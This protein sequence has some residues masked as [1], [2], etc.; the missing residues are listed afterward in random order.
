MVSWPLV[1]C[2]VP[3]WHGPLSFFLSFA[4]GIPSMATLEM[5][6][7][8]IAISDDIELP[9]FEEI[10]MRKMA[11]KHTFIDRTGDGAYSVPRFNAAP[12]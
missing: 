10:S 7:E 11:A 4:R 1:F 12:H 9:S 8:V 2:S 6:V 5:E 3:S